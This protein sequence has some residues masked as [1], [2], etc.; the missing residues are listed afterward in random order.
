MEG[1][2]LNEQ[3]TIQA[4]SH[5]FWA[6]QFARNISKDNKQYLLRVTS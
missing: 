2:I 4:T 5:V 1:C 3:G 6:M